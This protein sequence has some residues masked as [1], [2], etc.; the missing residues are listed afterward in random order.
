LNETGTRTL[1]FYDENAAT[2]AERNSFTKDVAAF[3]RNASLP[4]KPK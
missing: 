4:T 2:Y 1:S 3:F